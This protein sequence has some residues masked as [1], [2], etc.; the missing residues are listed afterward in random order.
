MGIFTALA[1]LGYSG[2][3]GL[4][5]FPAEDAETGLKRVHDYLKG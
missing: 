1:R 2:F 4:E 5:Y 3:I